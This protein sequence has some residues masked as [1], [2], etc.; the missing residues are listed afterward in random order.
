MKN[1]CPKGLNPLRST[2]DLLGFLT[3]LTTIL[4]AT[5]SIAADRNITDINVEKTHNRLELKLTTDKTASSNSSF[6]T[7]RKG[8]TIEANL[9]NTDLNLPTGEYFTP[10][11]TYFIFLTIFQINFKNVKMKNIYI[12]INIVYT[13][14]L[15][16]YRT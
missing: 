3:A 2:S 12:F 9:L 6:F 10:L 1:Y 8:N 16:Y 4:L 11:S 7:V 13:I 14:L 5:P 15:F